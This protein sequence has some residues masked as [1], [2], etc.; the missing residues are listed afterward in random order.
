LPVIILAQL[1]REE[2]VFGHGQRIEQGAGLENHGHL[3]ADPAKFVF[4]HAGD[5]LVR[6]DNF[7]AIG[8]DK[9][10][11]MAQGDGFSDAAAADDGYGFARIDIE[12]GIDQNRPVERLRDMPELDVMRKRII[13]RHGRPIPQGY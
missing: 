8:L 7:T 4:G 3:A 10:H 12:I 5:V 9:A 11:D 2:H 13:P 6:H 1:E